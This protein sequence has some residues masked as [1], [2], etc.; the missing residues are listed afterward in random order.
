MLDT[1]HHA[2]GTPIGQ[3]VLT[4]T[5]SLPGKC[6]PLACVVSNDAREG[7]R[8]KPSSRTLAWIRQKRRKARQRLQE[9]SD[10]LRHWL[11]CMA[12]QK[13]TE[14][15]KA[16]L[17][18]L[19]QVE[20]ELQQLEAE[21]AQRTADHRVRVASRRKQPT[22]EERT[23]VYEPWELEG[24]P[25]WKVMWLTRFS[26]PARYAKFRERERQRRQRKR[27]P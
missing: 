14:T 21:K 8:G 5:A 12:P 11:A 6:E 20:A 2:T 9:R 15:F 25:V 22:E 4:T 18:E 1:Q 10:E 3:A 24:L 7:G 13:A 26:H 16:R 19:G 27:E 23:R 17:A